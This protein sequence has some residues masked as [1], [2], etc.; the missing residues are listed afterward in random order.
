MTTI[1]DPLNIANEVLSQQA[2][3]KSQVLA[4]L[5]TQNSLQSQIKTASEFM[6]QKNDFLN[7]I[8]QN[9]IADIAL[10]NKQQFNA[11]IIKLPVVPP[12]ASALSQP[13]KAT[14][15]LWQN[16]F[17]SITA[18]LAKYDFRISVLSQQIETDVKT[19]VNEESDKPH[20]YFEERLNEFKSELAIQKQQAKKQRDEL[21]NA[22][23]LIIDL[24]EEIS[25]L[26]EESRNKNLNNK[27]SANPPD[28]NFKEAFFTFLESFNLIMDSA[29]HIDTAYYFLNWLKTLIETFLN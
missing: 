27:Q 22:K 1:Y 16:N 2:K 6:K 5:A 15:I 20:S 29:L 8:F 13:I 19:L 12:G 24:S 11:A 4:T 10:R 25:N 23:L 7:S 17:S 3:F 21:D 14:E 26:K 18:K 28:K 9:H